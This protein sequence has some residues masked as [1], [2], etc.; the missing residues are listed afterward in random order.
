MIES[1]K[2]EA[3]SSTYKKIKALLILLK[4]SRGI[5]YTRIAAGANVTNTYLSDVSNGSKPATEDLLFKLERFFL[6]DNVNQ[7]AK[8]ERELEDV[9]RQITVLREQTIEKFYAERQLTGAENRLPS[10]PEP[11]ENNDR[12]GSAPPVKPGKVSYGKAKRQKFSAKAYV[13]D[14]KARTLAKTKGAA[15]K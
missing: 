3:E 12:A 8:M 7:A 6:L 1:V 2:T 10:P 14:L 9:K 13:D 4:E 5:T 11:L 15:P